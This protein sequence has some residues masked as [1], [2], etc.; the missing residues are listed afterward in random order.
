MVAGGSNDNTASAVIK[1]SQYEVSPGKPKP[2]MPLGLLLTSTAFFG[3]WCGVGI[4]YAFDVAHAPWAFGGALGTASLAFFLRT[5]RRHKDN[6]DAVELQS[7]VHH[8]E[9]EAKALEAELARQSGAF[10]KWEKK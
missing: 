3:F 6:I 2:P 7:Q 10:D 8:L 1:M 9:V 4:G 5:I